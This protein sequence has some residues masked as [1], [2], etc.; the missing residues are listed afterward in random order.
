MKSMKMTIWMMTIVLCFGLTRAHGVLLNDG[1]IHNIFTTTGVIEI[2]DDDFFDRATTVNVLDGGWTTSISA[3]ERSVVNVSGGRIYGVLHAYDNS[4]VTVSDGHIDGGLRG[5]DSSKISISSGEIDIIWTTGNCELSISG[6][7]ILHALASS[8]SSRVTVSGCSIG[9]EVHT[10]GNSM[11]TFVGNDFGINSVPVGY[12]VFDSGGQGTVHGILTG[13]LA[14]GGSLDNEFWIR[15][16]A[17]IA[18]VPEPTTLLLLGLGVVLLRR[19]RNE[20]SADISLPR[21]S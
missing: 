1:L 7:S 21:V 9:Y 16:D 17:R 15:G 20:N 4:Q 18:L 10:E 8:G 3:Y 14:N 12:G 5:N 19:S 11:I 6:G 13:T 2:R